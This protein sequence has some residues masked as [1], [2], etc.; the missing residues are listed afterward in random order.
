MSMF[1]PSV[2]KDSMLAVLMGFALVTSAPIVASEPLESSAELADKPDSRPEVTQH[3]IVPLMLLRCTACHGLRRQEGDLDLRTK[4]SM[5]KGGKS[6]PAIVL[7][8]PEESLVLK[9]IHSGK[10]PPRDRLVD[11]GVKPI[12]E[13]ETERLAKWIE[14]GAPE[15]YVAPDVATDET[16]S[17]VTDKDRQFWAFQPLKEV[18]VPG[19]RRSERIRNPI[20]VFVLKKLVESDLSFSPEADRLTLLR[21]VYFD[22]IGLPPEPDEIE[23]FLED[24]ATDAYER[25]VDRLLASPRYGERWGRYWLDAAGYADSEGKRSA[26]PIRPYAYRYRDYVIRSFNDDKPYD[27][28][29]LEQIAGDELADYEN[30]PVITQEIVDNLVA[31]GFLRMAPDSTGA[32]VVNFTPERLEVISDEIEILGGVVLGLTLK[33]A[34]CHSHKYDPIPQRDY[35]RLVDI[36]KGAYDEHDWLKPTLVPGQTKAKSPGRV[37]PHVIPEERLHWEAHTAALDNEISALKE[38]L[39]QKAESVREKLLEERLS[40]LP[41]VLHADLRRMLATLPEKRD[42]ILK[43]LA[44]KFGTEL[45]ITDAQLEMVDP[46]YKRAATETEELVKAV[47]A[48]RLPKPL[49][50]ALWDRGEPSPTYIYRRG[51]YTNPGRLVGPG[52]PAV[53]TDGKTMFQAK[54]PWPGAEKTG[55]RLAL[56]RWLIDPDHPLTNRVML[57]RIWKH[58][59]GTGIVKSLD[60]FG[61]T[62]GRPSH[63]KLL[64]WLA[65]DFIEQGS[66]IKAMHR[67]M[68]TSRTYRQV[69]TRSSTDRDG[70]TVAYETIDPDNRLLS[71]MSMKRMEAEVL[72]DSILWV[73]GQ[74][75]SAQ[76]GRPD[77]VKY[78]KDGLVTSLPTERGWRRSVYIQQRRRRIPTILANF[79]L[80]QMNPNCIERIESTVTPQ[81]LHLMNNAMIYE[82][83]RHFAE[84]TYRETGSNHAEQ[85]QMVYLTALSRPPTDQE[86]TIG[87]QSLAELAELWTNELRRGTKKE[88]GE[89]LDRAAT[90]VQGEAPIPPKPQTEDIHT[91]SAVRA[92]TNYCHTILN[93]AQFLY[94]D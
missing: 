71:R 17:L 23:P 67:L 51:D 89:D 86:L 26:D 94:I 34:R 29:L 15:V 11:V 36:F 62:G 80:P 77:P 38:V 72:R 13:S 43:Y 31:T 73:C 63:P 32:D 50:R 45:K 58:H 75:D 6:G 48:R 47:E 64:D 85:I 79:D 20:D 14:L 82:L 19:L 56:A 92:L 10:M 18:S 76:F 68:M 87:T 93:S 3:E 24:D 54:P 88:S 7:G 81:A 9:M 5:L 1:G 28:F 35:Y 57:N 84:R 42:D 78:R 55:R 53:L 37:L 61:Q 22:L 30:V 49:I 21:R 70:D 65:G 39:Q 90:N 8:K 40:K 41:E 2:I 91:E 69:S 12:A 59:F 74:L 52:V 4:A 25:L 60:N 16:D 66:S 44:A 33:C 46:E 83:A 27:R